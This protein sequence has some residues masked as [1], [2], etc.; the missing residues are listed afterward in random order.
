MKKARAVAITELMRKE[1]FT[2]ASLSEGIGKTTK[3]RELAEAAKGL[4]CSFET[5]KLREDLIALRYTSQLEGLERPIA[6]K[7]KYAFPTTNEQRETGFFLTPDNPSGTSETWIGFTEHKKGYVNVAV[8]DCDNFLLHADVVVF[9]RNGECWSYRRVSED[10][11]ASPLSLSEGELH[12]VTSESGRRV[13]RLRLAFDDLVETSSVKVVYNAAGIQF[14]HH[15]EVTPEKPAL[16][17]DLELN[18][19]PRLLP[20]D[21]VIGV[22]D[23]AGRMVANAVVSI[24]VAR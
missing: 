2:G 18:D 22:A 15:F 3:S 19:N 17:S 5:K 13:L 7:H 16:V 6:I 24:E 20:G 10:Q 14:E 11:F 8:H 9:N 23:A 4:S 12:E 1:H 21:W